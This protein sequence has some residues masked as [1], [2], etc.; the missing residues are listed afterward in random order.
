MY[1]IDYNNHIRKYLDYVL[2]EIQ[3]IE[4]P[5]KKIPHSTKS[6]ST[7]P[8]HS[9]LQPPSVGG[10]MVYHFKGHKITFLIISYLLGLLHIHHFV[11]YF[12]VI[13]SKEINS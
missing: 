2:F 4:W 3:Y 5:N 11:E 6:I 1:K 12:Y 13:L 8:Q 10:Q 7:Y 9:N